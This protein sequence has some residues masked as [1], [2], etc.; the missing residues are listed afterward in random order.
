MIIKKTEKQKREIK[1]SR[2]SSQDFK[3]RIKNIQSVD[4]IDVEFEIVKPARIDG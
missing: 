4:I 2:R 1:I 3:N